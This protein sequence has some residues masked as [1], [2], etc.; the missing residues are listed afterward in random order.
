MT[1][2]EDKTM[3]T[4]VV[5]PTDNKK[6]FLTKR[7]L[8]GLLIGFVVGAI[9][10]VAALHLITDSPDVTP[11]YTLE[12]NYKI[13]PTNHAYTI[14]Q[15]QMF[16]AADGQPN[17]VPTYRQALSI[18]SAEAVPDR[19]LIENGLKDAFQAVINDPEKMDVT[20]VSHGLVEWP[21][22]ISRRVIATGAVLLLGN[23]EDQQLAQSWGLT[24]ADFKKFPTLP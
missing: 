6:K 14:R 13:N 15:V 10:M 8:K 19:D 22:P 5:E 1:T 12:Q 2:I 3:T 9:G 16:Y 17:V 11:I 4:T 7:N 20:S 18:L 24:S 23:V 21:A